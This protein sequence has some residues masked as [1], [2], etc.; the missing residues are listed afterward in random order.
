MAYYKQKWDKVLKSN[1]RPQRFFQ[2]TRAEVE[3][4]NSQCNGLNEDTKKLFAHVLV[5]TIFKIRKQATGDKIFIPVGIKF[6]ND[7]FPGAKWEKLVKRGLIEVK[8][9]SYAKGLTEVVLKFGTRV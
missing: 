8:P 5:C 7:N 2:A 6:I 1:A 3:W 9:Y 4:L